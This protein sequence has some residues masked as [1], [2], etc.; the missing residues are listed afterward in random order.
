MNM[1]IVLFLLSTGVVSSCDSQGLI[2]TK[3]LVMQQQK[4]IELVHNNDIEAVEKALENGV[5]VNTQ[6][7]N[8]RSLLL[9]ATINKQEAM[10]RLLVEKGADVNMQA[11]NQDSPFLYAGASGQTEL[12]RL[13]LGHGARFDVFNRYNGS[14]LIPAC[15]RGHV[16]TVKLLVDTEGYPID[17]INRLGWTGL[18]EAVVLGNGTKKYQEIVQVL[19]DGGADINIPDYD[20]VTP[21]QHAKKRGFNTIVEIL[22]N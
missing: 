16:E 15:E 19:K 18:M 2:T 10:A 17:H 8:K 11:D 4:I 5:G 7:N 6:D 20:G 3:E 9:L 1:R 22:S 13:F 12:V 14:A 21:L